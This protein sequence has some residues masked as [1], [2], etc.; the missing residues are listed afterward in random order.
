LER[1]YDCRVRVIADA[2]GHPEENY[3]YSEVADWK[4]RF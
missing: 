1:A 3:F 4:S 2:P